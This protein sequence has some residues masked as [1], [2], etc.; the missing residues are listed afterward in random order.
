[1]FEFSD[2]RQIPLIDLPAHVIFDVLVVPGSE[3]DSALLSMEPAVED[4]EEK[5]REPLLTRL[6][7]R[8]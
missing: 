1:M 2:G 6:L 5:E 4:D 3:Q 8:F 7:A